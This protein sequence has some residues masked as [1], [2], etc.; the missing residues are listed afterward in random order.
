MK[1]FLE[2]KISCCLLLP[3]LF[4]QSQDRICPANSDSSAAVTISTPKISI[5]SFPYIFHFPVK[6]YYQLY[7]S[8]A[9]LVN[10]KPSIKN[11]QQYFK[12]AGALWHL[13]K[14]ED[15][16]KMFL[17][18]VDSGKTS[19]SV[20]SNAFLS[21]L[22]NTPY[23]PDY[24]YQ[25]CIYLA[26]I[27]IEKSEFRNALVYLNKAANEYKPGYTCGTVRL[28]REQIYLSLY[29][30]CCKELNLTK[31]Y[32]D[33][34]LPEFITWRDDFLIEAIKEVYTPQQIADYFI[35]AKNSITCTIDSLPSTMYSA[36]DDGK[37]GR[38]WD[39]IIYYSSSATLD[40]FN[41]KITLGRI[42]KLLENKQELKNYYLKLYEE[43]EFYRK[44][45]KEERIV[46]N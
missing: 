43:S 15:A 25:G 8:S 23:L 14:I 29:S 36:A 19:T 39:T 5:S 2:I 17:T 16:E 4:C 18:I 42:F 44:L 41:R 46:R 27:N 35:Q 45:Y 10:L 33:I 40:L 31:D 11:Y 30:G 28:G 24:Q 37:G 38:R 6:E 9:Y 20:F 13:G 1:N 21:N 32:I 7:E 22:G 12:L 26:Q 34:V 3:V